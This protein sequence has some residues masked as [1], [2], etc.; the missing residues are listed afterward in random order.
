[1]T[2]PISESPSTGTSGSASP[3]D[4]YSDIPSTPTSEAT[5]PDLTDIFAGPFLPASVKGPERNGPPLPLAFPQLP[6]NATPLDVAE[7][8]RESADRWLKRNPDLVRLTGDHPFNCEARLDSLFDAGF[9]TPAHLHYVRNHGAVPPVDEEAALEWTIKIHGLVQEEVTLTLQELSKQFPVVTLPVTLVCAGNRRKEQNVVRKTMG[10]DWGAAGVSTALW[11]GVY[12][13]DVLEYV[14]PIR[15]EAKFVIFEGADSLI[16][17]EPYGTSQRLSWAASKEK[18]MLLAWAMN[19]LPLEPDHGFP[20]RL[21]V[22]GQIGGRSVKWLTR[23]EISKH[24]SQHTLHFRDN[25]ILPAPVTLA[26]ASKEDH[27]WSDPRYIITELN[28]NSAIAKPNHNETLTIDRTFPSDGE[29]PSYTIRGYA[30]AGGGRR[31]TRV[32]VSLDEGDS[33]ALADIEYPEDRFRE[34]SHELPIY[35]TLDLTERDTSFCWC[36]WSYKVG[37][38]ALG[39]CDAIMVRA[40]DESNAVQQ[41]DMYWHVLGMMN[42]WWFRIAVQKT[43]SEDKIELQFEHPTL[44]G[45]AKGGWMERM[46]VERKDILKP[47][48]GKSDSNT[49][50]I[51][52]EDEPDIPLT[53]PGVDRKITLEEL[54]NQDKQQPWIVINGEVYDTTTFLNEHPVGGGPIVGVAGKD[55]SEQFFEFHSPTA[56]AMLADLHIGTLAEPI[57]KESGVLDEESSTEFLNPT[58]MKAVKLCKIQKVNHD[59]VLY[60]F[61]LPKEDQSLGLPVGQH[62]MIRLKRKDNGKVIRRAYTPVSLEG[63][64]GFIDFLIKLYLPS[65]GFEGGE[66]TTRINQLVLG[67]EIELSGPF[68]PFIWERQGVA[69]WKGEER[70]V[71]EIGLICGGSGITPILQVLRSILDGDVDGMPKVWMI[72]ANKTEEDILCRSELDELLVKHYDGPARF[73]LHYVLSSDPGIVNNAPEVLTS[74]KGR[75]NKKLLEDHMPGPSKHGLILVCGPDMMISEAVKPGLVDAGWEIE[76]SLVVF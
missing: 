4:E 43:P 50:P 59:S 2:P 35:G 74:S 8:D 3:S 61:A 58:R 48:F 62:V 20:V 14:K 7:P 32:E 42:N 64:I 55:A 1:M 15:R 9:L 10:F 17:G 11:T 16:K 68:G 21:V 46:K 75:I 71:K 63:A 13:A 12:L 49:K 36:F 37:H 44:A 41:R 5:S 69:K 66:M 52:L 6:A 18:G 67:D 25:K 23:I 45:K 54:K 40:M 53:K 28:V 24:E 47:S 27:W 57:P 22:P 29:I 70:E 39:E 65:D 34:E 51:E 38:D 56:K 76:N 30:Y 33:W 73:R 19:G 60:R 72:S 31:V 26:Q